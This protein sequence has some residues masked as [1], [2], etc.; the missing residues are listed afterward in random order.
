MFRSFVVRPPVVAFTA[1]ASS[2]TIRA[3][4]VVK[5]AHVVTN[6]GRAYQPRTGI[7]TV[8][9]RGLYG[10]SC[11]LMSSP[12]NEVH[13]DLV[14]NGKRISSIFSAS[15]TY[16]QSSQTMYLFLRKGDRVWMQSADN[17]K[18]KLYDGNKYNVFSGALISML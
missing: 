16:P 17:H 12:Y 9:Y 5:Y 1:L 4:A 7:F 14:K 2:N 6:L 10:F 18:T 8:P 3:R 11:S 15:Y 13:L